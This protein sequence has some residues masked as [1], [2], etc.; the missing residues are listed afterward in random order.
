MVRLFLRI[1]MY[2]PL[3]YFTAGTVQAVAESLLLFLSFTKDPIIPFD[4]HDVCVAAA[5]NFHN[6]R[7]VRKF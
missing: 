5:G 2:F 7:Q 1:D 3:L 4:L 6:C